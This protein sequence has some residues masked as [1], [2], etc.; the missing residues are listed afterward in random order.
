MILTK[1]LHVIYNNPISINYYNLAV[2]RSPLRDSIDRELLKNNLDIFGNEALFL[3]FIHSSRVVL[4]LTPDV[5]TQINLNHGLPFGYSIIMGFTTHC[6][7]DQCI[8]LDKAT[9]LDGDPG[10]QYLS[11]YVYCLPEYLIPQFE[12]LQPIAPFEE[13]YQ[14]TPTME[15]NLS[16]HLHNHIITPLQNNQLIE[17]KQIVFQQLKLEP[18]IKKTFE[19]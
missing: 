19:Q 4:E 17:H 5:L 8:L 9:R 14:F 13:R 10:I 3:K 16:K 6:F 15:Q 11:T 12:N 2:V 18:F 1:I 7:N